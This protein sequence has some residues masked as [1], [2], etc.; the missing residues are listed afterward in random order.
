VVDFAITSGDY[1]LLKE[2]AGYP[3]YHIWGNDVNLPK[4][5]RDVD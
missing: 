3:S 5:C 2:T 4:E 1:P